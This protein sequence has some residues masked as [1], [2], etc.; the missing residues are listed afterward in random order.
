MH[1]NDSPDVH[2][3]EL[4]SERS[5][6]TAVIK[7]FP[8]S[9]KTTLTWHATQQ[10]AKGELFQQFSL[11]L[12]IPLRSTRVQQATCLADL[13]PHPD[14]EQRKAIAQAISACNG[15]GVCFWFDGWDE[16]PQEVQ[17]ESFITSF[18][19]RDCPGSSLPECVTVVTARPEAS[20]LEMSRVMWINGLSTDQVNEIIEKRLE[21][22]D[23][24]PSEL[25]A[26]LE[27]N[28]SLQSACFVPINIAIMISLFLTLYSLQSEEIA[29]F[30]N[31]FGSCRDLPPV[32]SGLNTVFVDAHVWPGK[33]ECETIKA[34]NERRKRIQPWRC[35]FKVVTCVESDEDEDEN[36]WAHCIKHT[37]FDR[38]VIL[39]SASV[40][41]QW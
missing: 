14:R 40:F 27:K 20:Y 7:G 41:T 17:R 18:I 33:M 26:S 5:V 23:R 1:E 30:M 25:I 15:E 32:N 36:G 16:M 21:G 8:G 37:G 29:L 24:N 28:T 39:G 12:S 2:L 11:L 34:I 6:R 4:F 13:I 3:S 31:Y 38:K 9:G 19:R 22:T 10:W 35:L